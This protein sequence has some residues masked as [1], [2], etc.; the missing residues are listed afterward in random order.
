MGT[1]GVG[2]LDNDTAGDLAVF[3][4]RFITRGRKQDPRFWT[5]KAI[6]D[7]FRFSYFRGFT[8]LSANDPVTAEELLAIGAL[9]HKHRIKLPSELKRLVEA[10]ANAELR[11]QRLREW[12]TSTE[13]RQAVEE[14]LRAIGGRRR[15]QRARQRPVEP[16]IASITAFMSRLPH[17]IRV[18]KQEVKYEDAYDQAEPEFLTD[19]KDCFGRGTLHRDPA[20][21]RQAVRHRLMCLAYFTGW[22]LALDAAEILRLVKVAKGSGRGDPRYAWTPEVWSKP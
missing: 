2:P 19:L 8:G 18:V 10:A 9:F 16:E 7:L 13:R 3:W 15:R 14:F 17:W 6:A 12:S 21:Q 4:D 5:P 20:V 11:P 1:W 22:M